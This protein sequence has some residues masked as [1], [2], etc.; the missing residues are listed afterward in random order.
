VKARSAPRGAPHEPRAYRLHLPCAL[1][2]PLTC[3]DEI[4]HTLPA[5][6]VL[7]AV[8]GSVAD[9]D[10]LTVEVTLSHDTTTK[11]DGVRPDVEAALV[12]ASAEPGRYEVVHPKYSPG[13]QS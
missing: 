6:T 2:E 5:G 7:L 3:G 13:G 12:F 11:L 8:Q 9:R 1:G 10:P 4:R